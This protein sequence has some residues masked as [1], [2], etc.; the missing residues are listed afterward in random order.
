MA[1]KKNMHGLESREDNI[2][3]RKI[4]YGRKE[5]GGYK[6]KIILARKKKKKSFVFENSGV[7]VGV[8]AGFVARGGPESSPLRSS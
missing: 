2:L 7:G 1:H 8:V 6:C 3:R 4:W 5:G